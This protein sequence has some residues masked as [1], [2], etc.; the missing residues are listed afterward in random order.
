MKRGGEGG[1]E[2]RE[3]EERAD[4]FFILISFNERQ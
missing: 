1:G 3:A 4:C 2:R